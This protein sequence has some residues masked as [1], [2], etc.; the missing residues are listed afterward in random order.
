MKSWVCVNPNSL[1]LAVRGE[2]FRFFLPKT[3]DGDR[4]ESLSSSFFLFR[5]PTSS[6][7][8][9]EVG[10]CLKLEDDTWVLSFVWSILSS[11]NIFCARASAWLENATFLPL[12]V[13]NPANP[14][15]RTAV[16]AAWLLWSISWTD[17]FWQFSYIC[18]A[19]AKA[20]ADTETPFPLAVLKPA[21]PLLRTVQVAGGRSGVSLSSWKFSVWQSSK[22]CFALAIDFAEMATPFPLAVLNPAAPLSRVEV[23]TENEE[24]TLDGSSWSNS[25]W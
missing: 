19:R 2:S 23:R 9:T 7:T 15:V 16:A 6:S 1:E 8:F 25:D 20:S 24:Q 12:A 4:S 21:G 3:G 22:I 18:L 11:T 5:W 13:L 17:S 14:S 10:V